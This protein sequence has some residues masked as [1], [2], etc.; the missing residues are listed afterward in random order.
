MARDPYE[1]L[2]VARSASAD[3]IKSAYR[4]LARETHPDVNPNDPKAEDR[5]KEIGEAYGVLSDA[6]K[7]ARFDRYGVTDDQPQAGPGDF[8]GGGGAGGFQDLFDMFL[9]GA[10]GGGQARR[11]NGR[12]GEDVR[13]DLKFSYLDVLNGSTRAVKYRKDVR[14]HGC[15]GLGTADGKPPKTCPTCAGQGV[16]TSVKNTFLGQVRTQSPCNTCGGEG[17]VIEEPCKV[18]RGRKTIAKEV[19]ESL[20]VP[21]GFDDGATMRVP[22][23][24]GEGV[25]MGRPGDLYAVLGIED[26]ARFER[27]GQNLYMRVPL[28]YAQAV[29]GDKITVQGLDAA[30]DLDIKP[31]TQPGTLMAQRRQGLPPLHGGAR[32]DLVVETTVHVPTKVSDEEADL[33]RKLAALQGGH[34]PEE[35]GIGG[36]L[37]GLFG[38][39]K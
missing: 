24:G 29:L 18:C 33:L 20:T 13:V 15:D 7:K 4:R 35:S 2:G 31:G 38:R 1:V 28:S 26:D 37:G 6:E 27:D 30:I 10:A 3:E 9:G 21:A 11:R 5:F 8:F 39:K 34:V 22:G 14:C 36:F 23:K 17:S 32:G 16:V 25:G 12:D 19:E